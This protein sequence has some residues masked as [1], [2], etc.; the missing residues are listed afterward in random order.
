MSE[1]KPFE[2]ALDGSAALGPFELVVD[3]PSYPK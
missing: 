1:S 2:Y 3:A